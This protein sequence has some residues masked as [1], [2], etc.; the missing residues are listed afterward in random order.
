LNDNTRAPIWTRIV[1][2]AP[3]YGD[4]ESLTDRLIPVVWLRPGRE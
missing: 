3:Q 1:A 2:E 4:Y